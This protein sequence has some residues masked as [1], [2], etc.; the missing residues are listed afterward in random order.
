MASADDINSSLQNIGRN[1]GQWVNVFNGRNVAGTFRLAAATTT[2]IAQPAV[3]A[4]SIVLLT[5]ANASA[6]LTQITAGLYVAAQTA[7]TGFAVA[8]QS[9]AAMGTEVFN[10]FVFS[11]S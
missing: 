4:N 3:N 2:N 11:P 5:A 6:A 1:L 7:G 9:G 8:T 10:Y